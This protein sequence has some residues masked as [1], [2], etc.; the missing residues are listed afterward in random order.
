MGGSIPASVLARGR[1]P[2]PVDV[3]AGRRGIDRNQRWK[4]RG[5]PPTAL[6]VP[7]QPKRSVLSNSGRL[8]ARPRQ[9]IV[10][11]SFLQLL[12]DFAVG[13]YRENV[14]V[15]G[16]LRGRSCKRCEVIAVVMML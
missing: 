10:R 2:R 15:F 12:K 14:G 6:P 8:L 1:R 16:N 4:P 9:K 11:V 13:V 5:S 7:I 3:R